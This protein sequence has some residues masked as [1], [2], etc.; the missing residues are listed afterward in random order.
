MKNV[1]WHLRCPSYCICFWR[2]ESSLDKTWKKC[3]DQTWVISKRMYINWSCVSYFLGAAYS[4]Q[5]HLLS[6]K[7]KERPIS[8]FE[9]LLVL[10]EKT[11][12]K[13]N[14]GLWYWSCRYKF[15]RLRR[16]VHERWP[17]QGFSKCALLCNL[18]KR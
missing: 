4:I 13:K 9:D 5:L 17:C 7:K 1:K 16:K 12:M 6:S 3:L 10:E 18:N 14:T 11:G 2:H 8:D 15:C